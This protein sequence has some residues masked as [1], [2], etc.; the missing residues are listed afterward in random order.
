MLVEAATRVRPAERQPHLLFLGQEIVAG[1]A[2]DLEYASGEH[3]GRG[4]LSAWLL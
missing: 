1:V 4:G 2:V 3:R